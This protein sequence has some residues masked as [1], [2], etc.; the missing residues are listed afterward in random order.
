MELT[1][2]YLV[3]H[4]MSMGNITG[5]FCGQTDVGLCDEGYYQ[6]DFLA[7]RFEDIHVDRMYSSPLT[8]AV[9]TAKAANRSHKLDIILRYDLQ[10]FDAGG[11]EKKTAD[12]LKRLYPVEL[13]D[14]MNH[15][16]RF[17][18]PGGESMAQLRE[19]SLKA[20]RRI[21]DE[22]RG[23]SV[24]VITHGDF[25]RSYTCALLGLSLDEQKSVRYNPNTGI[26]R[27]DYDDGLNAKLIFSGDADHL[28]KR[29]LSELEKY[30]MGDELKG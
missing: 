10:E 12:E 15:P 9:E 11:F 29:E 1:T 3:R 7:R 13:D 8:R 17:C 16:G 24:A 25:I 6:L 4:A 14:Y 18:A 30:L 2:I 23:L 26:T 20:I 21:A 28:P 19:R 27:V 22:C 5:M